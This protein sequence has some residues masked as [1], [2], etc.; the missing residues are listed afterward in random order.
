MRGKITHKEFVLH[1]KGKRSLRIT[2]K[3]MLN[4]RYVRYELDLR[5]SGQDLAKKTCEHRNDSYDCIRTENK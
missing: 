3:S 2:L 1:P 5:G 4:K